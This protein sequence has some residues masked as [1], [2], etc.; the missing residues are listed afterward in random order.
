MFFV[1]DKSTKRRRGTYSTIKRA[2]RAR[3]RFD[4][5]YGCYQHFIVDIN[6]HQY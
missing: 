3:D 5:D 1:I 6:G 2:R 4:N